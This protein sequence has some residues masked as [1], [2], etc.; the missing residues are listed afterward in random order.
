MKNIIFIIFPIMMFFNSINAQP[1]NISGEWKGI[2]RYNVDI[3]LNLQQRGEHITGVLIGIQGRHKFSIALEGAYKNGNLNY[4]YTKVLSNSSSIAPCLG[5]VAAKFSRDDVYGYFKGR[6]INRSTHHRG[7]RDTDIQFRRIKKV[8]MPPVPEHNKPEITL[9]EIKKKP[10]YSCQAIQNFSVIPEKNAF[11]LNWKAIPNVKSYSI[12][13]KKKSEEGYRR[14]SKTGTNA[15]IE[16]L[17]PNTIYQVFIVTECYNGTQKYGITKELKTLLVP[18]PKYIEV[19]KKEVIPSSKLENRTVIVRKSFS[20]NQAK[21]TLS[22]WDNLQEDGDIVSIVLNG[23][24]VLEE[25]TLL[26]KPKLVEIELQ[27][28]ENTIVMYA[29][30]LGEQSPN[31]AKMRVILNGKNYDINLSSSLIKSEAIT[32]VYQ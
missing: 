31:T 30:N 28:G 1:T 4:T 8:E 15:R 10:S 27:K 11:V 2:V 13:I 19:E 32:I 9:P 29:H 12:Y 17:E 16:S 5:K 21:L 24:I 6:F 3:T 26:N 23:K 7:C 22:V 14:H 20:S 18:K 25:Y